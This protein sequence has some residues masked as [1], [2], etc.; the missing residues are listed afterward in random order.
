MPVLPASHIT[1]VSDDLA[2][3]FGWHVFFLSLHEPEL[4]LLAVALRLQL[5]PF[6][7]Y[8]KRTRQTIVEIGSDI[9]ARRMEATPGLAHLSPA[10]LPLRAAC[11]L[12][13]ELVASPIGE[14]GRWPCPPRRTIRG[15]ALRSSN[16][17]CKTH[18]DRPH[19]IY[20]RILS[21]IFI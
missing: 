14:A 10:V 9:K 2:H 17:F 12:G 6:L 8:T 5:L 15:N 7:S 16:A 4:S 13:K 19:D 18:V 20:T 1:V 3:V 21:N 11:R